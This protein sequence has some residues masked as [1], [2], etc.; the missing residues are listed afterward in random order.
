MKLHF[1][2]RTNYFMIKNEEDEPAVGLFLTSDKPPIRSSG[3]GYK[4]RY[5]PS[6]YI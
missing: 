5:I 2:L 6:V 4:K 3:N 1:I